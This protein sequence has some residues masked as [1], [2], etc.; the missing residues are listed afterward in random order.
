MERL[1][2]VGTRGPDVDSL[3]GSNEYT[4]DKYGKKCAGIDRLSDKTS[5]GLVF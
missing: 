5:I 2:G 3:G 4:T 1:R